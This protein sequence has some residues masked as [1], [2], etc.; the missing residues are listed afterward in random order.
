LSDLR[1]T[2]ASRLLQNGESPAYVK[3]QMGYLRALF[4]H[5]LITNIARY[6][7]MDKAFDRLALLKRNPTVYSDY[8]QLKDDSSDA[9]Y[10]M[11]RPTTA[12]GHDFRDGE[13]RRIRDFVLAYRQH[14]T[15]ATRREAPP[16]SVVRPNAETP[17]AAASHSAAPAATFKLDATDARSGQPYSNRTLPPLSTPARVHGVGRQT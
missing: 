3:E 12:D 14:E 10:N 2:F 1:H 15:G 11:W 9:R 6:G 8:R 7:D 17:D 13:L 5:N 4:A 16:K